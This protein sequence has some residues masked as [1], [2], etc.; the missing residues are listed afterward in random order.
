[1]KDQELE[2]AGIDV[3]DM[4]A[5]F[6]NNAKLAKMIVGKFLQDQTYANLC[7]AIAREDRKQAEFYCHTLKG[8]CGNLSLKKLFGLLVEQLRLF[9]AGEYDQAVA[10]ME[11]ISACYEVATR[12]LTLW[13]AQE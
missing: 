11:E 13:L 1:M 10:M 3:Q 6:M 9:R 12:H 8:V 5:R 2:L 4:M 7:Q